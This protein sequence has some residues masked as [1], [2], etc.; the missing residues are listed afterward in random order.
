MC[1]PIPHWN[2]IN[3]QPLMPNGLKGFFGATALV[4]VSF[5]GVTKVAAIAE[6]VKDPQT[7]LPKGILFSLFMVTIIYCIVSFILAGVYHY[8]DIAGEIRP[9][10]RL[11]FD[12]GG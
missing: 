7:N 9:I 3:L 2:P 12:V 6:E 1:F 4:F 5:A 11:A 10:Y 8:Q